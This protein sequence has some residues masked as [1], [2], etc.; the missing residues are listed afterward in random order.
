MLA[1]AL[2]ILSA[3]LVF[4][5]SRGAWL[6]TLVGFLII[7]GLRRQF[8][9][10]LRAGVI[11]LLVAGVLCFVPEE[12]QQYAFDFSA[13]RV[14]IK[15]RYE[16]IDLARHYF[17]QSPVFGVGVGLRE[18]VDATN[19]FWF[20]LAETGVL[21]LVNLPADLRCLPLDGLDDAEANSSHR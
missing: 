14:N 9:L 3:G 15:A 19:V 5:L 2:A 16:L 11:I 20:T 8:T 21:G 18:Q 13:S 17:E 4:S 10:L 6:G 12:K 7:L 1:W